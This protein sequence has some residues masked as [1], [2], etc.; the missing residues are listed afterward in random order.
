M[1]SDRTAAPFDN[2]IA[3]SSILLIITYKHK[4]TGITHAMHT[5]TKQKTTT[6]ER[7]ETDHLR[8]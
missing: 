1:P 3:I 8:F 5:Y 2:F 4:Y 7:L 6:S